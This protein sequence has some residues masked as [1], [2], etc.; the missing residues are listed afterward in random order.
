MKVRVLYYTPDEA[1]LPVMK[2]VFA[3]YENI[4]A[5]VI[6]DLQ[7]AKAFCVAYEVQLVL[8]SG[9]LQEADQRQFKEWL[10]IHFPALKTAQHYGGGSALL[11]A[12]LK[13]NFNQI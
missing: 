1:L 5:A 8:F 9:G 6:C 12:T 13:S 11:Y 4:E 3:R 10:K 7:Q 2:R